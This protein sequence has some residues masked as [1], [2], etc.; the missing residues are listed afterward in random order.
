MQEGIQQTKECL[1]LSDSKGEGEHVSGD[2][3]IRD[4]QDLTRVW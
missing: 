3:S 1:G 4:L 2:L